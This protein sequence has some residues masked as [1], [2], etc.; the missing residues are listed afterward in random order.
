MEDLEV[1]EP[2]K[3]E[4]APKVTPHVT[5]GSSIGPSDYSKE[6]WP[7]QQR[8]KGST[9]DVNHF[10]TSRLPGGEQKRRATVRGRSDTLE[11]GPSS[12]PSSPSME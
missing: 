10:L 7:M 8:R 1:R 6:R 3:E 12:L 2:E 11:A 4:S 9:V 5:V